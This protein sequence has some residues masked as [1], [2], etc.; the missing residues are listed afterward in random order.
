[1]MS[2]QAQQTQKRKGSL[3]KTSQA[4]PCGI[5][6]IERLSSAH[7]TLCQMCH[8]LLQLLGVGAGATNVKNRE[9]A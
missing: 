8:T 1:M 6:H 4:A 9:A 7:A 5:P 2:L 3:K